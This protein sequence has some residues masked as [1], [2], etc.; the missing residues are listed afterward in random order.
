MD[1]SM[2]VAAVQPRQ[3]DNIRGQK[4][5]VQIVLQALALGRSV[6]P[7]NEHDRR[8]ETPRTWRTRSMQGGT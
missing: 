5:L 3:F 6:L 7:S 4:L 8:S 1:A 2:T